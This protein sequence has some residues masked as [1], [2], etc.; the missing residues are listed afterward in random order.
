MLII[1]FNF[2]LIEQKHFLKF[3]NEINHT[4]YVTTLFHITKTHE[5]QQQQQRFK[6]KRQSN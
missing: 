2:L 1:F 6:D 4:I 3:F 5:Q